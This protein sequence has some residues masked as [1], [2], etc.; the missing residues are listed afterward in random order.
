ML[1]YKTITNEPKL[2]FAVRLIVCQ[3]FSRGTSLKKLPRQNIKLNAKSSS[4]SAERE[5]ARSQKDI[6]IVE[7]LKKVKNKVRTIFPRGTRLLVLSFQ[8]PRNAKRKEEGERER[9]RNSRFF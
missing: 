7:S 8:L 9:E 2:T 1:V 3:F 6:T 5:R 4:R